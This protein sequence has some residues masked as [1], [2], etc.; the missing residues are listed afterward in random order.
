M[1]SKIDSIIAN[2]NPAGPAVVT[3]GADDAYFKTVDCADWKKS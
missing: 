3:I 2:E 1:K